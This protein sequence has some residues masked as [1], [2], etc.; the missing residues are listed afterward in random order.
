MGLMWFLQRLGF[1]RVFRI[2]SVFT[3]FGGGVNGS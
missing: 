3:G 2:S 1:M